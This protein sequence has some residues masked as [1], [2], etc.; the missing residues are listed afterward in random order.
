MNEKV[1]EALSAE[2]CASKI[3]ELSGVKFEPEI[4]ADLWSKILQHKW[5]LSEKLSRDVGYRT[6]C[7][8]FLENMEQAVNEYLSYQRR[9]I[10]NEMG[11]QN[12]RKRHLG[13]LSR[14]PSRPNT[15][16]TAESFFP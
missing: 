5:L 10:L 13:I 14:I 4:A 15:L 8:D 2:E 11:A 3:F 12:L 7:I 1:S 9:D 16:S 6:A